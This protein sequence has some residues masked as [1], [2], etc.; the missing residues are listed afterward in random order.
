MDKKPAPRAFGERLET[1]ASE[2]LCK[3]GLIPVARNFQCKLGEIDLIM[4][5][6]DILVFVEVRYRKSDRYGSAVESVD[7]RKQRKLSRTAQL[8]LS[9]KRLHHKTPCRFDIVGISPLSNAA[10]YRFDW[11]SNAFGLYGQ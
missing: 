6:N 4:R 7:W 1:I 10:G 5:D 8:Y 9:A 2:Y 3:H 11:R